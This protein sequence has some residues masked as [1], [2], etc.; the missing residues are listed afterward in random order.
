MPLMQHYTASKR[1][2]G[3]HIVTLRTNLTASGW[4]LWQDCRFLRASAG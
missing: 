3:F 2:A 1:L 4:Q